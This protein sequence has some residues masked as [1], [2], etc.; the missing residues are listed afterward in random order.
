MRVRPTMA[1]HCKCTHRSQNKHL[2]TAGLS[3]N[4]SSAP[5]V[6]FGLQL[7]KGGRSSTIARGQWNKHRLQAAGGD[8]AK[9]ASA[10]ATATVM[11]M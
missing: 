9:H 2:P 8:A 1:S 3:G 6:V 4:R 11:T 10:T 7:D 5:Q